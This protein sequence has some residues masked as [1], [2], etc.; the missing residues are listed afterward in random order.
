MFDSFA[1]IHTVYQFVLVFLFLNKK[2][3]GLLFSVVVV[4]V[5]LSFVVV[6]FSF[7]MD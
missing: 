1:I 7:H 3:S 5:F 6:V 2:V 4:V